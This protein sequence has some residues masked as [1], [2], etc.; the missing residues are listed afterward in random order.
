MT[1][2]TDPYRIKAA[3]ND[4][5]EGEPIPLDLSGNPAGAL[6]ALAVAAGEPVDQTSIDAFADYC[7]APVER[8]QT[9]LEGEIGECDPPDPREVTSRWPDDM[10]RH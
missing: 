4:A 10:T 6:R 8:V 3:R 2:K 5:E 1:K 7:D 9:A